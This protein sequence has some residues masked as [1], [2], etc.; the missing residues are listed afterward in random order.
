MSKKRCTH[1][2]LKSR[3]STLVTQR[4]IPVPS[5]SEGENTKRGERMRGWGVGGEDGVTDFWP[6]GIIYGTVRGT[7]CYRNLRS[8]FEAGTITTH[9]DPY[10]DRKGLAQTWPNGTSFDGSSWLAWTNWTKGPAFATLQTRS[11]VALGHTL[12]NYS[13]LCPLKLPMCPL[14][15]FVYILRHQNS[16]P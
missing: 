15:S 16:L 3:T 5:V 11:E 12:W 6:I 2:R 14:W 8:T 13:P 4:L 1:A 9:L 7:R 10:M